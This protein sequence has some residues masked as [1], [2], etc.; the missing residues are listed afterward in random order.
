MKVFKDG[1]VSL[2]ETVKK[3]SLALFKRPPQKTISKQGKKIQVLQ[4]VVYLVNFTSPCNRDGDLRKILCPRDT[5]F[6][7]F[8]LKIG[9]VALAKQKSEIS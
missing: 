2:H 9:K 8:S 7:T 1:S 6:P 5:I 4:N 3:N